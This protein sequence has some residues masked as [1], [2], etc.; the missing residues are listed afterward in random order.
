M[1]PKQAPRPEPT[2]RKPPGHSPTP[3]GVDSLQSRC[4]A[5][6]GW[7]WT[8]R[9]AIVPHFTEPD[10]RTTCNGSLS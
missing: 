9:G 2:Q 5:C 8:I 7:A 4:P 1:P 10:Y 6:G 3:S